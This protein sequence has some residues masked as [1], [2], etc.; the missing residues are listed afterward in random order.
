MSQGE[1]REMEG[2]KEGRRIEV[3]VVSGR[4]WVC[5]CVRACLCV[6]E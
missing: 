2:K 4:A 5:A 1:K 3:Y 6:C